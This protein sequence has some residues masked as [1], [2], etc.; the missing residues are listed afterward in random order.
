LRNAVA[1]R[2]AGRARGA[3]SARRDDRHPRAPDGNRWCSRSATT[4]AASI[5]QR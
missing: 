3:A 2:R 4:A 1:R 5:P